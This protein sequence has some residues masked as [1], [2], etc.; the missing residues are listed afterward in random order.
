M[1]PYLPPVMQT[2]IFFITQVMLIILVLGLISTLRFA[3]RHAYSRL[4]VPI[5]SQRRRLW[6]AGG[7]LLLWLSL[8]AVLAGTGWFGQLTHTPPLVFYVL[9]PPLLFFWGLLFWP[10]FRRILKVTPKSW[11]FYAQTY[12]ILTDLILWLGYLAYFVPKQLTFLWLNQDYTVGLTAIVAGMVFFGHGQNRKF[13]GVIWNIFGSILLFNQV[14]LGYISL[15]M[16]DPVMNT[17]VDSIFL[18]RFPFIWLWGFT[19]PLGFGLH[20]ASLYQILFLNGP[21][22]RRGF[23]LQRPPKNNSSS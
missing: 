12:R 18:T 22:T 5:S 1:N 2:T 23:S 6:V 21:K 15:P 10:P 9:F 8:L 19:I 7:G 20:I 14:F 4:Q 17:G 13:E 3:L 16:P 11:L